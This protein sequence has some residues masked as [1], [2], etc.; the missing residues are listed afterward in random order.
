MD[1]HWQSERASKSGT[2]LQSNSSSFRSSYK[3]G[4][5]PQRAFRQD[6]NVWWDGVNP[7]EQ[8]EGCNVGWRC[9]PTLHKIWGLKG[10]IWEQRQQTSLSDIHSAVLATSD[11]RTSTLNGV[12]VFAYNCTFCEF[13]FTR[14]CKKENSLTYGSAEYWTVKKVTQWQAEKQYVTVLSSLNS[15]APMTTPRKG[16]W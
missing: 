6:V 7:S 11:L 1:K 15:V 2:S 8:N 14:E 3:Q 13:T 16:H 5:Q 4:H 10:F 12:G 9:T